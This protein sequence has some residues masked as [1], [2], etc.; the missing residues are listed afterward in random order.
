MLK[1]SPAFL[2]GMWFFTEELDK[3]EKVCYITRT[4]LYLVF[5]ID[6]L[7]AVQRVKDSVERIP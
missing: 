4:K 5:N 6:T 2:Q 3:D 1:V 7:N